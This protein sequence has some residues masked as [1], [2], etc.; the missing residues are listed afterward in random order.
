V[1]VYLFDTTTLAL[2]AEEVALQRGLPAEVVPSPPGADDKCG[3]AL[4][5]PVAH[6]GTLEAAMNEEGIAWERAEGPGV[7]SDPG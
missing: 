4:R 3:L 6:G 5:T 7:G 1:Y 2:W